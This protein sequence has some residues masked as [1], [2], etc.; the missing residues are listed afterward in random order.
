MRLQQR[1]NYS[2]PKIGVVIGSGGL[3]ALGAVALF[4]F[5]ATAQIKPDLLVG[6]SAG[7]LMCAF[8]ATG[9]TAQ[10]IK[11]VLAQSLHRRLF[12]Q[13]DYRTLLGMALPRLFGSS[14]PR[15]LFKAE[16]LQ[17]LLH[18]LFGEQR[19]E[20][21]ATPTLLQATDLN[22]GNGV[23]LSRGC[24]ADAVYASSTVLTVLPPQEF[25]GRLLADGVYS[26]PL[27]VMEAVKR[28]MDIIIALDFQANVTQAPR[29]P[30]DCV[31][32]SADT[33]CQSLTYS[34]MFTSMDL[35]HHAIIPIRVQF[36]RN[37]SLLDVHELPTILATTEQAIARHKEEILHA[38]AV[39]RQQLAPPL[40][41]HASA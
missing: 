6:C 16:R 32:F 34:Q 39:A 2:E 37:I 10:D 7:S 15:G 36:E 31:Q 5:L 20:T 33:F 1:S 21:L 12:T 23:V 38:I 41:R 17:A 11:T 19:L 24:L 18:R 26:S 9:Y 29:T 13:L 8:Q 14:E 25:E 40:R 30:L 22:T 3:K 35:H 28:G 4:E 27:P